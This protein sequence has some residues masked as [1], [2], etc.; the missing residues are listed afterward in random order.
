MR[1]VS[2]FFN[3]FAYSFIGVTSSFF[4]GLRHTFPPVCPVHFYFSYKKRAGYLF[5]NLL[6]FLIFGLAP[7][8][9]DIAPEGSFYF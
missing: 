3:E 1:D 6:F 4:K 5:D 7:Y 9:N 2:V 8:P